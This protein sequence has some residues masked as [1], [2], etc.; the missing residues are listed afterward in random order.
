M[1]KTAKKK[2]KWTYICLN[3]GDKYGPFSSKQVAM[4]HAAEELCDEDE[5]IV[6]KESDYELYRVV[7]KRTYER[8]GE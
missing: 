7:C 4:E 3:S 6:M 5:F 2:E 8:I 1:K